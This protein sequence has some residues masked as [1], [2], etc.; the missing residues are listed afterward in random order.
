MV[1]WGHWTVTVLCSFSLCHA[2]VMCS[3]CLCPCVT[4]SK[5]DVILLTFH[6]W[7]SYSLP[8]C[9]YQAST[10]LT[11]EFYLQSC[12]YYL[13]LFYMFDCFADI[14]EF[15]A[16]SCLVFTETIGSHEWELQVVMSHHVGARNWT[17]DF[18]KRA[19]SAFNHWNISLVLCISLLQL[20]TLNAFER[21]W[22][23]WSLD[24]WKLGSE[25][26]TRHF[27]TPVCMC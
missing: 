14:C 24:V 15:I 7:R 5:W 20:K 2:S 6:V 27:S 10:Y 3:V 17:P 1:A 13:N 26:Y 23:D 25:Y 21:E 19:T 11:C 22:T 12:I 18:C 8:V 16:H 4:Y 9:I